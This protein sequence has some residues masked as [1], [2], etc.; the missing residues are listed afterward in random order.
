MANKEAPKPKDTDKEPNPKDV[1]KETDKALKEEK[2][3]TD[4][5]TDKA[6]DTVVATNTKKRKLL[7]ANIL[8]EPRL[9]MNGGTPQAETLNVVEEV[10][11]KVQQVAESKLEAVSKVSKEKNFLQQLGSS[12]AGMA[13]SLFNYQRLF[14]YEPNIDKLHQ[15]ALNTNE[16][17]TTSIVSNQGI[18]IS[19]SQ[20]L[21]LSSLTSTSIHA[22]IS[23]ENASAAYKN[24]EGIYTLANFSQG[25]YEL[26][27]NQSNKLINT[28]KHNI[29]VFTLA[30]SKSKDNILEATNSYTETSQ[31]IARYSANDSSLTD[32]HKLQ[33][34]NDSLY[35]TQ[36][37]SL[38]ISNG[39]PIANNINSLLSIEIPG[40]NPN[41]SLMV[42]G[43]GTVSTNSTKQI[44]NTV[45]KM[46]SV[47]KFIEN[48]AKEKAT[49]LTDLHNVYSDTSVILGAKGF[50]SGTSLKSATTLIGKFTFMGGFLS[51]IYTGQS[52]MSI[53]KN[54]LSNV[55]IPIK[56]P[57]P[58][59][60]PKPKGYDSKDIDDCVPKTRTEEPES[61]YQ[62]SPIDPTLFYT[63]FLEDLEPY[64]HLGDTI[65]K[66]FT[67]RRNLARFNRE[68]DR[69][70]KEIEKYKAYSKEAKELGDIK[71][72]L[73]LR[74]V[75][76]INKIRELNNRLTSLGIDLSQFNF[77]TI[78]FKELI[79][80][81]INDLPLDADID[82]G[83]RVSIPPPSN[84]DNPVDS[85]AGSS[86]TNTQ[87]SNN[88]EAG[89]YQQ[90][91]RR[92]DSLP[93]LE[94][95]A[96]KKK[97]ELSSNNETGNKVDSKDSSGSL[98]SSA[99]TT[100]FTSLRYQVSSRRETKGLEGTKK[101]AISPG[102][103]INLFGLDIDNTDDKSQDIE[104]NSISTL[105]AF[106]KLSLSILSKAIDEDTSLSDTDKALLKE[107]GDKIL[108]EIK[109]KKSFKGIATALS[110]DS[111]YDEV[112][113]SL[114][115]KL[116]SYIGT[117]F[118]CL[119]DKGLSRV[120]GAGN[121]YLDNLDKISDLVVN[122]P[123]RG[124][125]AEEDFGRDLLFT[126]NKSKDPISDIKKVFSRSLIR[127]Y[128]LTP[129]INP[130]IP[131]PYS[132]LYR[133]YKTID[134]DFKNIETLVSS[135]VDNLLQDKEVI[136][137]TYE[138]HVRPLVKEVLDTYKAE[139]FSGL[140]SKV[141]QD[142]NTRELIKKKA[143]EFIDSKTKFIGGINTLK[144]IP[145]LFKLLTKYDIPLLERV[146]TI[147]DCLDILEEARNIFNEDIL[148]EI[149]L[150]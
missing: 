87:D 9:L 12:L 106:E 83:P 135:L 128:G 47:G 35:Q 20:G 49:T 111:K 42:F 7:P 45:P 103:Y 102:S 50:I 44:K 38:V 145:K 59:L 30:E 136:I 62:N 118:L 77:G 29:G 69:V 3:T 60:P 27:Y 150:N 120:K 141:T 55:T 78:T 144:K 6:E 84:S 140:V 105:E 122:I 22:P 89:D 13:K 71:I 61:D 121:R 114:D 137:D 72:D 23:V 100:R 73:S 17:N 109:N 56:L 11:H 131:D 80:Y 132:A 108:A 25:R 124:I 53:A 5:E 119:I 21:N 129:G 14:T 147:M 76:I 86:S 15:A 134:G 57:I 117:G 8:T 113:E 28:G 66:L 123:N 92:R 142:T 36:S 95:D 82:T 143:E 93:S 74:Q 96:Y 40:I 52:L 1:A 112:I 125:E 79:S 149:I 26:S 97:K 2:A 110:L 54:V 4:K 63:P 107:N 75:G 39:R 67:L 133:T 116:T 139:G 64:E 10:T 90:Y 101:P 138:E 18:Q 94:E 99:F 58:A 33:V 65:V 81:D 31:N 130:S 148:E 34:S 85:S 48:V 41:Q 16:G 126:L 146:N 68:I 70:S 46:T 32:N 51:A 104:S 98:S 88:E 115:S 19:S 24:Y 91:R 37:G 127:K 43:N